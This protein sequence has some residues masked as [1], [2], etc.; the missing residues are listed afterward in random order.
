MKLEEAKRILEN[1]TFGDPL[2]IEAV[3]RLR[4]AEEENHGDEEGNASL[5]KGYKIV[6]EAFAINPLDPKLTSEQR[7]AAV[8]KHAVVRNRAAAF[9]RLTLQVK[10][11]DARIAELEAKLKELEDTI[12]DVNGGGK[13]A[14]EGQPTNVR[15]AV[16]D[17]FR[18]R[19]K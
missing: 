18:K 5:E 19:A 3:Q 10:S 12:P 16:F 2:C 14:A 11:K 13:P 1:P 7:A 6:D 8:K 4:D 15:E 17:A 9:G